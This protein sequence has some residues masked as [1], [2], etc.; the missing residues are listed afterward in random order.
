MYPWGEVILEDGLSGGSQRRRLFSAPLKSPASPTPF[1]RDA[2]AYAQQFSARDE[3]AEL[4]Y[5]L[6][7]GPKLRRE[8]I[9]PIAWGQRVSN[10]AVFNG[11]VCASTGN[12]TRSVYDPKKHAYLSDHLAQMYGRVFC[13]EL[14]NQ[15][16]TTGPVA[17]NGHARFIVTP[18]S[19]RVDID[20]KTV[21][22]TPHHL[23][24]RDLAALSGGMV[25]LGDGSYG[26]IRGIANVVRQ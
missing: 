11:K 8:G 16:M 4:V 22:E 25:T 14:E 24:P 7:D 17:M 3:K 26:K 5:S 1:F 21:A 15:T 18:T 19:M 23:A 20:G 2:Y 10:I 6:V 9:E 12:A 13:A